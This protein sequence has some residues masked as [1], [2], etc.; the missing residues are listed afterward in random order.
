MLFA[1]VVRVLGVS[2]LAAQAGQGLGYCTFVRIQKC[3]CWTVRVVQLRVRSE[4]RL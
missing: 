3:K 2:Q 4:A 1:H